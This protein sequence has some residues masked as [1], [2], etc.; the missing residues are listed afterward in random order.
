MTS[1]TW[2]DA[3]LTGR[4][5]R[6]KAITRAKKRAR[7]VETLEVRNLLAANPIGAQFLVNETEALEASPAAVAVAEGDGNGY[8]TTW[9]N[10]EQAGG[11]TSGLGVY[12]Q[13]YFADG[14]PNG[15]DFLVNSAYTDG[16]QGSPDVAIDGSGNFVIVWESPDEDGDGFGIYAQRYLANGTADGTA[17]KVNEYTTGDQQNPTV[18]RDN[19]GRFV[20][21]WQSDGQDGDGYGIYARRYAADGT[22]ID[23]NEFLVNTTTAGDQKMPT[24][25]VARDN[26]N[27]VIAWEGDVAAAETSVEVLARV[28]DSTGGT[29]R[30]EFQ[31]NTVVP[32]DQVT[33]DVAMDAD[34]DF[35]VA[36]TTEGQPGSGSDVQAQLFDETGTTVGGE[37]RVNETTLQ[38]QVNPSVGMDQD[39]DILVIVAEQPSRRI[40]LGNL[41]PSV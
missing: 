40:Q 7:L 4:T 10:Y 12:A 29:I 41:W 31:V 23:T 5:S 25:A 6:R 16:D 33:P 37:F 39:G 34:G 8:V 13:R 27:F 32:R 22:A 24:A 30:D 14:S 1:A 36:W 18:V 17:F 9:T 20:I 3:I 15:P 2:L 19:A 26:G 28:Y 35:I 21:A 11:D 38:G